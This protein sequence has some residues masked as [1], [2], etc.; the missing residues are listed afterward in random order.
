MTRAKAH[1]LVAQGA[2]DDRP[3]MRCEHCGAEE[4]VQTP[5]PVRALVKVIDAFGRKH[6]PCRKSSGERK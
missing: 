4:I 1:V 3:F 6:R 5:L 2:T